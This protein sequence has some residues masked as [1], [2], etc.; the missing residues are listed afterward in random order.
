MAKMVVQG[1]EIIS[2]EK[3]YIKWDTRPLKVSTQAAMITRY[4]GSTVER[5]GISPAQAWIKFG[6][7]IES[8][9][10]LVGHNV[11]GFDYYM[12]NAFCDEAKVERP[13]FL[14]KIID[15]AMLAKA[16]K[17]GV[18]LKKGDDLLLF[19]YKM[20]HKKVKGVKYSLSVM[21]KELGI[22]HDYANLHDALIDLELNVK[23]WQKLK[24]LIEV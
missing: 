24:W 17:L 15:T 23:V 2:R 9:D 6:Q 10:Y 16:Y 5:E 20:Y 7:E 13:Q 3:W 1:D 19:Q 4:S 12:I 8:C 21:G 18:P 14:N 11:L 22:P